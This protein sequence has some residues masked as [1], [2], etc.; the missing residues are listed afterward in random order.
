MAINII[1]TVANSKPFKVLGAS[2][3]LRLKFLGLLNV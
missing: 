2:M 1:R 3:H